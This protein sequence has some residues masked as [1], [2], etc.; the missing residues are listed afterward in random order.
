M[1]IICCIG[2]GFG[3]LLVSCIVVYFINLFEAKGKT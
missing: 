2:F 1:N 3:L